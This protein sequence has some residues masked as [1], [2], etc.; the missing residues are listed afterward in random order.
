MV[1]FKVLWLPE[2]IHREIKVKASKKGI[3]MT[4]LVQELIQNDNY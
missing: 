3:T 1:A 2:E 4:K